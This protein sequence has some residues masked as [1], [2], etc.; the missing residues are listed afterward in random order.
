MLRMRVVSSTHLA[1]RRP[2]T[3]QKSLVPGQALTFRF[4]TPLIEERRHPGP[5]ECLG[6][7]GAEGVRAK[8]VILPA[9]EQRRRTLLYTR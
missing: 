9:R 2:P 4:E 6:S 1:V 7:S 8:G 5:G 3:G